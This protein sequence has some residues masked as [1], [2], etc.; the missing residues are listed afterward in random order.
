MSC[1]RLPNV[2]IL[3]FCLFSLDYLWVWA[4]CQTKQDVNISLWAPHY[5]VWCHCMITVACWRVIVFSLWENFSATA[6]GRLD[7]P[8]PSYC[9]SDH[10]SCPYRKPRPNCRLSNNMTW[11]RL[12]EGSSSS[13]RTS[14]FPSLDN[15]LFRKW[16]SSG[17]RKAFVCE[18]R[19]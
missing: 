4:V 11:S 12:W 7:S 10:C 2:R 5:W 14:C 13:R 18:R 15:W 17:D 19:K 3:C 9:S 6:A 8:T 16:T 1:F